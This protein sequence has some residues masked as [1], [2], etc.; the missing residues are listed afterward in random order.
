MEKS[1]LIYVE[2]VLSRNQPDQPIAALVGKVPHV[3]WQ[4]A[5]Q[6]VSY[7]T[8]ALLALLSAVQHVTS[9][10]MWMRTGEAAGVHEGQVPDTLLC[11]TG[12][13]LTGAHVRSKR[14]LH[15]R[16]KQSILR[17]QKRQMT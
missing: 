11:F 12:L 15:Q 17:L 1:Q 6:V 3:H 5:L 8:H 2:G 16:W 4:L 14:P 10:C 13:Q 7:L 9:R